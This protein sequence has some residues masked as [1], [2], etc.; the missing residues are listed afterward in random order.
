MNGN[1]KSLTTPASAVEVDA[2]LHRLERSGARATP[3]RGRLLFA[4][5][6]TGSRQAAWDH[7]ARIQAEM[8]IA[9][10]AV[11]GLKIQLCF[12]RGYGEFKVSPWLADAAPL[13]RMMTSVSC[14]AGETQIARVLQHAINEAMAQRVGALVFVGDCCEETID[15]LAARAGQL[16]A[17]GVPAFMFHEGAD[18]RAAQAFQEIARLTRGAYC[19][20][21]AASPDALRQLLCAVAVYAAGGGPA[22]LRHA[23]AAGGDVKRIAQQVTQRRDGR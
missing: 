18:P 22:L 2:F 15:P 1:D 23:A 14:R 3:T 4:L 7:A 10:Q 13:L 17:L 19:R 9:A 11:G 20:F 8:F 21:D 12:Y 5:D 16:G 6:A